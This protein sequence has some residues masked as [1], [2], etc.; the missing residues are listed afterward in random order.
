MAPLKLSLDS[1]YRGDT[2]GGF[3]LDSI[4]IDGSVPA[5]DLA[6]CRMQFRSKAGELGY[7]LNSVTATC[8][9]AITIIDATTWEIS[10]GG[11]P[12]LLDKGVW[13]W[14]LEMTDVNDEIIT[15]LKGRLRVKA[16]I[17]HY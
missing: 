10:I 8:K 13:F 4:T 15:I 7:E 11:Y 12:L 6:S 2:W 1:Y 17:T 16:D 5:V 14:D 9:A 3:T